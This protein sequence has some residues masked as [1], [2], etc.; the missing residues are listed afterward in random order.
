MKDTALIYLYRN[1]IA[2]RCTGYDDL[3]LPVVLSI[4]TFRA[5]DHDTSIYVIDS[6]DSPVKWDRFPQKLNFTVVAQP[7]VLRRIS[8]C[9]TITDDNNIYWSLLTK[10]LDFHNF[11]L[12]IPEKTILASDCD[13]FF[14]KSM[15]PL[16]L[17]PRK[18]FCCGRKT[19]FYYY[20]NTSPV[21]STVFDIWKGLC[22][23]AV[24]D[25]VIQKKVLDDKSA[26]DQTVFNYILDKYD[27]NIK[28]LPPEE[29]F[30]L[31][32]L[33]DQPDIHNLDLIKVLHL[34][35]A[36]GRKGRGAIALYVKELKESIT[37]VLSDD[38]LELLF[39]GFECPSY[40]LKAIRDMLPIIHNTI[41]ADDRI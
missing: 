38:D 9:M 41:K 28:P 40:S 1:W 35:N 33:I 21:T 32:W 31:Q 36:V 30:E 2:E 8:D 12:T 4:A 16:L 19:G 5:F 13:V 3:V 15:F 37:S 24:V 18:H 11:S 26:Q 6:S 27:F 23:L 29:N 17:D 25:P 10:P 39:N 7:C 14:L 20:D 34:G 22:S